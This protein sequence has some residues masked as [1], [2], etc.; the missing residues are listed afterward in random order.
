MF[1]KLLIKIGLLEDPKKAI[2]KFLAEIAANE[3]AT[4]PFTPRKTTKK[5]API[6]KSA[7]KK[8]PAKKKTAKKTK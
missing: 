7:A 4:I 3:K 2:E 8:T 5:K 6:K 1:K